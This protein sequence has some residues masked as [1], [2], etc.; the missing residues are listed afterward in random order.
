MDI[1]KEYQAALDGGYDKL[2]KK[3]NKYKMAIIVE[4]CH[5]GNVSGY[6]IT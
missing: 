2:M 6:A 5:G 1:F 4:H 3:I